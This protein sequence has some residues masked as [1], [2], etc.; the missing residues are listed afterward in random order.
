MDLRVNEETKEIISTFYLSPSVKAS[1]LKTLKE[2]RNLYVSLKTYEHLKN[3]IN[4]KYEYTLKNAERGYIITIVG[5]K[6][7]TRNNTKQG[8]EKAKPIR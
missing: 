7:E 5:E 2:Q 4:S 8:N 3:E 1:L 6:D